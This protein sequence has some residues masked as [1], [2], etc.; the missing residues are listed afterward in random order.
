MKKLLLT[1][2]A[3]L[4]CSFLISAQD[5]GYR[6]TYTDTAAGSQTLDLEKGGIAAIMTS[7]HEMRLV[8]VDS[9]C[10]G[11]LMYQATLPDAIISMSVHAVNNDVIAV[12]QTSKA[13]YLK[14]F[15]LSGSTLTLVGDW[16]KIFTG[17]EMN[18]YMKVAKA[19]WGVSVLIKYKDGT[20]DY[21]STA[22]LKFNQPAHFGFPQQSTC[23][24]YAGILADDHY[25]YLLWTDATGG[26]IEKR[27]IDATMTFGDNYPIFTAT[28]P[29][30]T[31]YYQRDTTIVVEAT[32][33]TTAN[34]LVRQLVDKTSPTLIGYYATL[35]Y[36]IATQTCDDIGKSIDLSMTMYAGIILKHTD[37]VNGTLNPFNSA[38]FGVNYSCFKT[39][40]LNPNHFM[41]SGLGNNGN[42]PYAVWLMNNILTKVD[43]V[44]ISDGA[45]MFRAGDIRMSATTYATYGA[46]LQTGF[47]KVHLIGMQNI[48]TEVKVTANPNTDEFVIYPNPAQNW[49][50][51]KTPGMVIKKVIICDMVGF[52]VMTQD[53][54]NDDAITVGVYKLAPAPYV[55]K[56]YGANGSIVARKFIKN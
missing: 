50:N 53:G 11:V 24:C 30:I 17:N 19:N 44:M 29:T 31:D 39:L 42:G 6:C 32:D 10:H 28:N 1:L 12:A 16:Y 49:L 46:N 27:N 7:S 34:T 26:Y 51:A 2:A 25:N 13:I 54:T 8:K 38:S 15:T 33:N 23:N 45:T 36:P 55:I 18:Q 35:N 9:N 5:I 37:N 14:Y 40:S 41:W 47:A 21:F 52:P 3:S 43:S 48:P 4:W 20:T 56:I 22:Q